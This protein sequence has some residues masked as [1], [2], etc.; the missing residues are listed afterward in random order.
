MIKLSVIIP[1]YNVRDYLEQCVD[2]VL[3]Q[4][5]KCDLE[6]IL[7]DDGSNDGSE[8][9][10]DEYAGKYPRVKVIH[11]ENE[12]LSSAKN[13][14]IDAAS[15][16]YIIFLDSDD[17]WIPRSL[18]YF[19][20]TEQETHAD[21][22]IGCVIQYRQ[23]DKIYCDYPNNITENLQSLS[24]NDALKEILKPENHFKWHVWKIFYKTELI[25]KNQ[26]YFVKGLFFEDIEWTPRV[27]YYA[28]SF[29]SFD[30]IFIC[31][32]IQ[33]AGSI[34]FNPAFRVKRMQDML[35]VTASL[36]GFFNQIYHNVDL[37]AFFLTSISETYFYVFIRQVL[38][39]DYV[40]KQLLKQQLFL[41][42]YYK[43]KGSKL[44][45]IMLKLFGYSLTCFFVRAAGG[46]LF[47]L[48]YE[49]E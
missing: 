39:T 45:R 21:I 43:G 27:F 3:N 48:R 36:T 38:L 2:S 42:N 4:E 12:G 9:I 1:V 13:C 44:I 5:C 46:F 41:L 17:F 15:G 24:R 49:K 16:D 11:K 47:K 7:V 6:V 28:A 32:R 40:S 23:L 29:A 14:G 35:K 20:K 30:K 19:I 31:Y 22:I 33:R 37:R 8:L 25:K 26:L 18:K 34:T 10:C